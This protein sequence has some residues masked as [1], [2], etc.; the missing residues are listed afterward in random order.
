MKT[1]HIVVASFVGIV[2]TLVACDSE[3]STDDI[4]QSA[5]KSESQ[6]TAA[7]YPS[8]AERTKGR[9][10]KNSSVRDRSAAHTKR[11]TEIPDDPHSQVRWKAT[12]NVVSGTARRVAEAAENL[13]GE[14]MAG[15]LILPGVEQP[16]GNETLQELITFVR[17]EHGFNDAILKR[18][19]SGLGVGF[20][21]VRK[22]SIA[23]DPAS[24]RTIDLT[25]DFGCNRLNL[26][27]AGSTTLLQSTHF[28]EIR[29]RFVVL[30]QH[31]LPDDPELSRL[32]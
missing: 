17:S 8:T 28:D 4:K 24:E 5:E 20:R 7:A 10:S 22:P 18:C 25:V 16:L 2:F 9:N 15:Y 13:Q 14:R 11:T 29:N 21:L 1:T 19:K 12:A 31:A 3:S 6:K 26:A 30:V 27:Y 23:E 32:R